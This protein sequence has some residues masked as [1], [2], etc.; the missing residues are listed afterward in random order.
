MLSQF[1]KGK[2]GAWPVALSEGRSCSKWAAV[3]EQASAP[4]ES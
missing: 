2:H 4:D 3:Q 1:D